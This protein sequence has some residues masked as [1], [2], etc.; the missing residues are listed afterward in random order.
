MGE[1]DMSVISCCKIEVKDYINISVQLKV[2][3]VVS[4]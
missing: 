4:A 1:K 2:S 3:S